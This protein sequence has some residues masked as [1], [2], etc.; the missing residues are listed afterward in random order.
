MKL[1]MPSKGAAA[2]IGVG[3][4]T[5]KQI[6]QQC[7]VRV[8][9]DMNT[10]P[11][12][13]VVFE[14]AVLLSGAS[15]QIQQALPLVLEQL[16]QLAAEKGLNGWAAHSNAGVEIPGFTLFSPKGDGKKG[17]GGKSVPSGKSNHHNPFSVP[18]RDPNQL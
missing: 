18:P 13:G 6:R 11:C 8:N 12:S 2:I 9:V 5:V 7:N 16:S 1:V 17:G 3:G 10:V 15:V 14:Q 4:A